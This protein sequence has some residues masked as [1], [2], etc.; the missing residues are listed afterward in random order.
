MRENKEEMDWETILCFEERIKVCIP[1][2]LAIPSEQTVKKKFPYDRRPEE[3]YMD[4]EGKRILT[5]SL[6]E[7]SLGEKQVHSAVREIQ[8]MTGHLYPE[9]IRQQAAVLRTAGGA[10]GWF[11]FITGGLEED[12]VHILFLMSLS[13]KMMLGSYH[14]PAQNAKEEKEKGRKL[15]KSIS[16]CQENQEET[17]KSYAGRG[18]R[19]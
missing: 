18:I 1:G 14:F 15:I 16:I 7:T 4:S 3:I 2:E 19:R 13:G 5:F 9:S 6:L 12:C 11:S 17:V 10:A 8:R